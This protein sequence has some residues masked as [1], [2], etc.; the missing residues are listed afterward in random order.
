MP[1][2]RFRHALRVVLI[3]TTAVLC[4]GT[5]ATA[6]LSLGG[7]FGPPELSWIERT[8]PVADSVSA[9]HAASFGIL[10]RDRGITD[11]MPREA[12]LSVGNSEI[13]G[14]NGRA[15]TSVHHAHRA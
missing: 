15:I 6:A 9:S 14:R 11:Q 12:E 3:G 13:A 2:I 4:G 1:L 7:N 10:R 5:A 8:V